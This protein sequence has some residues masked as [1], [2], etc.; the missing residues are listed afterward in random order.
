MAGVDRRD[1]ASVWREARVDEDEEIECLAYAPSCDVIVSGSR[2]GKLHFI[3][4]QTGE[5]ILCLMSC[6][7][8]VNS[9]AFRDNMIAA[10]CSSGEIKICSRT[11]SGE[12]GEIQF[13]FPL[14]CGPEVRSLELSPDGAFL[15]AGLAY[16]SYSVLLFDP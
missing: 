6:G 14:S 1:L 12:W 15:T 13:E 16:S 10:G 7:S 3:N 8:H 4:A 2:A 11:Q 9:I 5:K